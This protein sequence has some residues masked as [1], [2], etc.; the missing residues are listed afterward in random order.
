MDLHFFKTNA[1]LREWMEE[2]H[3]VA[4]ELWIGFYKVGSGR[5]SVTYQ[6]ALDE[7]LC[8]GWIDGVRKRVDKDSYTIRFTRRKRGSIWSRVNT[9]RVAELKALGL[10]QPSGLKAFEERDPEKTERYSYERNAF[11]LDPLY[12][13]RFKA[14]ATAWTFFQSQPPWYRKAATSWVMS[15]KKQET[16]DKRMATLIAVS[17]DGRT[18]A[19]LTR[20]SRRNEN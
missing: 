1:E 9:E 2:N 15:A 5:P 18:L 3:A 6:G 10:M 11:T 19:P 8:F 13:E 7:A 16:R 20:P 4:P 12:E 17:E 14:D